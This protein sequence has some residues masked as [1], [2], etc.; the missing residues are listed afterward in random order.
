MLTAGR[1]S[2][3][4]AVY[5]KA[6]SLSFGHAGL[7]I[8]GTLIYS[9]TAC[10][11]SSSGSATP[12]YTSVTCHLP[13]MSFK[14]LQAIVVSALSWVL[15]K[16]FRQF[17]V[18]SPLDN[19]PGPPAGSWVYGASTYLADNPSVDTCCRKFETDP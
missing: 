3:P 9:P 11:G 1:N 16:Y 17:F 5:D 15:W 7:H 14:V 18:S 13:K 10:S 2:P 4:N 8:V 6:G 19:I 12:L